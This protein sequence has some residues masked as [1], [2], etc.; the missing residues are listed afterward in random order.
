MRRP[1]VRVLDDADLAEAL[2]VLDRDPVANVFVRSRIGWG[3]I[4]PWRLGAELWGFSYGERLDALCYVG[5]NVVPAGAGPEAVQAF[6]A[7]LCRSARRCSAI[8]GPAEMVAPLWRELGSLWGSPRDVRPC[9]PLMTI[10]AAPEVPPDPQVRPVRSEEFDL[11]LPAAIAM[12]TEEVGVSP[13]G[14]DGGKLYRA[15]V[16][17]LI[18]TGRAFARIEGSTVVFKAEI[19]ASTPAVCQVQGVWVHPDWRGKGLAAPGVASVVAAARDLF[20]PVVSLYVNDF[21]AAARRA[22]TNV[23]FRQVG[24]FM[25][26]LF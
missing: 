15:R 8:V 13:L 1:G 17:E 21:N 25:S 20:A 3:G 7:R 10:C 14:R 6:G 16:S 9:Q 26:V 24:T 22:Y 5:S 11:L 2:V 4:A 19:G 23:G 12:F 18:R